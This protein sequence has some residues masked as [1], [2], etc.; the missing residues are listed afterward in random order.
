VLVNVLL[1]A[2][3]INV[4]LAA[5]NMIPIPPLDAPHLAG[6]VPERWNGGYEQFERIG[7]CC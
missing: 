5:F 4:I 1:Q 3:W 2:V 6:I 7:P